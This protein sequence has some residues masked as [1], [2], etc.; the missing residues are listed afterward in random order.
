MTRDPMEQ[1]LHDLR[2]EYERGLRGMAR[3]D[4]QRRDLQRTL[5]RI[6]GAVQVLEEL[7][8]QDQVIS[9]TGS[10]ETQ[11]SNGTVPRAVGT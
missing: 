11:T 2:A 4:E 7:L 1:R 6:S 5:L 9:P 3:L 8:E 10:P